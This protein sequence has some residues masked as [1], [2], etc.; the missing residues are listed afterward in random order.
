MHR[1]TPGFR[2]LHFGDVVDLYLLDDERDNNV[3]IVDQL[4]SLLVT[5]F[6]AGGR[7]PPAVLPGRSRSRSPTR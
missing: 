7:T 3:V 1:H 4:A 2:T 5:G 6:G